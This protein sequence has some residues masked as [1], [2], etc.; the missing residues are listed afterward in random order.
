MRGY[1]III[2]VLGVSTVNSTATKV[3]VKE[4]TTLRAIAEIYLFKMFSATSQ[5]F[6]GKHL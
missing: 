1:I 6:S 2:G 4:M 5:L 3:F